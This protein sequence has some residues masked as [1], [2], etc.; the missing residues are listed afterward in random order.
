MLGSNFTPD[1]AVFQ[2]VHKNLL[3]LHR[4]MG[5]TQI[6]YEQKVNPANLV[7][8]DESGKRKPT[9]NREA[10]LFAAGL[11]THVMSF[12]YSFNIPYGDVHISS[13]R[14]D[15]IGRDVA[16]G[17]RRDAKE[18]SIALNKKVKATDRLKRLTFV[19]AQQLGTSP[20]NADEADAFGIMDYRLHL[21]GIQ[22][23]WRT[24]ETLIPPLG[25]DK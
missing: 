7:T 21:A 9:T 12:C 22:P 25:G 19:R 23:P 1:G 15:F 3:D 13:W 17:A 2:K 14:G 6:W 20:A 5:L 8:T 16:A 11:E 18:K 4:V 10:V 24:E